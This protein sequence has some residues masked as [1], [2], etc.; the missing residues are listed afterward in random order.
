MIE[1]EDS[2][3]GGTHAGSIKG[4]VTIKAKYGL[5][6]DGKSA[7]HSRIGGIGGRI[8]K[9]GGYTGNHAAAALNGRIGGSRS[10]KGYTF[11]FEDDKGKHYL[12]IATQEQVVFTENIMPTRPP[13][14]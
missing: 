9:G 5:T 13:R 7:L 10:K 1:R 6:P 3:I 12:N 2:Y 4:M 8:S 11:L 14:S